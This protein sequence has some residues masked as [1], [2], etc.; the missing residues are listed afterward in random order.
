M[1]NTPSSLVAA[2]KAKSTSPGAARV[3]AAPSIRREIANRHDFTAR[4]HEAKNDST[5]FSE[6]RETASLA[7]MRSR[8]LPWRLKARV[9][10]HAP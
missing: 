6:R 4:M 7:V 10:R 5:F 3:M 1:S 9:S 8:H 2:L